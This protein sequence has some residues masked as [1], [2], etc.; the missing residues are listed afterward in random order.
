VVDFGLAPERVGALVDAL[1]ADGAFGD[2]VACLV[3]TKPLPKSFTF[4]ESP[5]A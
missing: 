4:V 5:P 3:E 2:E 1:H